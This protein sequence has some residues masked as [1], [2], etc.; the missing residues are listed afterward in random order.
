MC[1]WS[2]MPPI[3][4]GRPPT[5]LIMPPMYANTRPRSSLRILT[6]VLLTWNIR[7]TSIFTN[8]FAILFLF[9][10]PF[11]GLSSISICLQGFRYAPPPACSLISPSGLSTLTV[12]LQGFRFATPPAC[13]LP[14]LSGIMRNWRWNYKSGQTKVKEVVHQNLHCHNGSFF[15]P[16]D[17][18]AERRV[19]L[20]TMLLLRHL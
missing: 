12:T 9:C 7:C 13:S 14:P 1:I 3:S 15:H 17:H 16:I 18:L 5:P 8:V 19:R 6:L 2:G 10:H 4:T 20:I 11:R